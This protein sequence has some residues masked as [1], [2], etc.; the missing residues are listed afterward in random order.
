[1]GHLNINRL[2]NKFERI[3]EV[4]FN[5]IDVF[6]LSETKPGE[7]FPSNQFQ[8]ERYKNFRLDRNCYR[9][10]VCMYDNQDIAAG[11][12][13]YNSVSNIESICLKLNLRKT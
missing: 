12:V 3:K 9:G 7:T 10:G 5:N 11:R 2:R 13:E 8:I 4:F 1:M 6:F